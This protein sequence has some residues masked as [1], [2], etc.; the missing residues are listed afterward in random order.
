MAA[1]YIIYPASKILTMQNIVK[2][3]S[4]FVR[5]TNKKVL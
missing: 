2:R 1:I 4:Y 3:K 5:E